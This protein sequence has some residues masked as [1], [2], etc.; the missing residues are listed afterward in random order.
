VGEKEA[1]VGISARS[2]KVMGQQMK[3]V[4]VCVYICYFVNLGKASPNR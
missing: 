3:C 4:Y 2:V 1:R